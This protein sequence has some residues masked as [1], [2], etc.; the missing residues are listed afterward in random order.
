MKTIKNILLIALVLLIQSTIMG[1]FDLFGVRPDLGMLILLY[2]ANSSGSSESVWYGFMIGFLQDVYT[3]EYLG[4]NTFTM[5]IIGYL[6]GFVNERVTMEKIPVRIVV[7]LFA[8]ILHDLLF[9][10]LYTHLDLSLAFNL[11]VFTGFLGA[12]YT[13]VLSVLFITVLEWA[14]KGGLLIIV[15][16]LL[17]NRR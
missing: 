17:A 13:T 8:C 5:S 3:P 2:I 1:R 15:N 14:E 4:F 7:T 11:Y 9:V 12:V 6:L 10:S 16:E